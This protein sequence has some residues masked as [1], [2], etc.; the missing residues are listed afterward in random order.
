MRQAAE[1]NTTNKSTSIKFLEMMQEF[2]RKSKI[3]EFKIIKVTKK[4]EEQPQ[5][6]IHA[7]RI[8]RYKKERNITSIN[9]K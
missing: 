2:G 4:K 1:A 5:R 3:P 8:G 7:Q 9:E 6:G